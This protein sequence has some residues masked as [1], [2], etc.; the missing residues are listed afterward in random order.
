MTL[1]FQMRR[2]DILAFTLEFN[3]NSPTFQRIRTRTRLMFPLIMVGLCL[4]TWTTLGFN[5]VRTTIYLTFAALWY[6]L[7]P[8]RFDRRIERYSQ[9]TLD[10]AC[11]RKSLGPCELTLTE[12]GLHSKSHTGESTFYWSTVDRVAMTD[13]HVFIFLSG[14]QGYPIPIADVGEEAAK[15]AYE[16][17]LT[18]KTNTS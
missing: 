15:A 4:F 17:V 12:S 8:G 1:N 7:F 16:F 10:E 6:L 14:P 9:K 18:H 11:H 3:A 2:E 5:S 13:T